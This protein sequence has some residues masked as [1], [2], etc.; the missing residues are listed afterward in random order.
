[1]RVRLSGF[2]FSIDMRQVVDSRTLEDE[3]Y[4]N[5]LT[6]M[7]KDKKGNLGHRNSN[8]QASSALKSNSN[9]N[10]NNNN[11]NNILT[12]VEPSS[13]I[14]PELHEAIVSNK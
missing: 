13:Y 8:F 3:E 14:S 7:K 11:N 5:K 9:T 6:A 12:G 1:M 4:K 2:D 10:V